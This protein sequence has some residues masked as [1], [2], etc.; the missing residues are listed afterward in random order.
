M[1]EAVTAMIAQSKELEQLAAGAP[2]QQHQAQQQQQQQQAQQPHHQRRLM[3]VDGD[4]HGSQD[5]SRLVEPFALSTD[6]SAPSRHLLQ[7]G[8]GHAPG[9][10]AG[11]TTAG[12][13]AD[14]TAPA[15]VPGVELDPNHAGLT[16]E[17]LDSFK[18][19]E[20]APADAAGEAGGSAGGADSQAAEDVAAALG[21]VAGDAAAAVGGEQGVGKSDEALAQEEHHT[22]QMDYDEFGDSLKADMWKPQGRGRQPGLEGRWGLLCVWPTGAHGNA[23]GGSEHPATA[24]PRSCPPAAE[25]QILALVMKRD[26]VFAGAPLP[27]LRCCCLHGSQELRHR[28]PVVAAHPSQTACQPG[29]MRASCRCAQQCATFCSFMSQVQQRTPAT[30]P[31][32]GVVAGPLLC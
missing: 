29:M 20:D 8:Q 30:C 24:G 26:H 14:G 7:E 23:L 28:Q 4:S 2:A 17:A 22:R 10:A 13:A 21:D 19:F 5:D 16:Q 3:S 27:A 18:I 1:Y 11:G 15:V 12:N 31:G 25:D 32:P 9:H 6:S